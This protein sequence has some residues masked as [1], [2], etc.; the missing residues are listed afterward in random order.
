MERLSK[1]IYKGKEI[2]YV[3]YSNFKLDKMKTFNLVFNCA[4]EYMKYP[5]KSVLAI[6]NLTN[7]YFDTDIIDAFK[8]TQEQT[9]PHQKRVALIGIK[10]LQL[11]AYNYIVHLNYRDKV[12]IFNNIL[13]AKEWL[14]LD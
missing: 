5:L 7:L 1:I 3:D 13:E 4:N 12:R 9:T 11:L 2:I 6:V 8:M 14:V 10:G